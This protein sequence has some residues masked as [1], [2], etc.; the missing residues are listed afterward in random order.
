[1][2]RVFLILVIVLLAIMLWRGL[3]RNI[4]SRTRTDR[5]TTRNM[6]RCDQ[7]GLHVP[8]DA[9]LRLHGRNYCSEEHMRRDNKR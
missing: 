7:C 3:R 5:P 1:M 8:E 4:E 6:I 2:T 9:I